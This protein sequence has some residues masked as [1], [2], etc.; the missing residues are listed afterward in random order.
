MGQRRPDAV[1]KPANC[2]GTRSASG[3]LRSGEG[4]QLQLLFADTEKG[5]P[6]MFWQSSAAALNRYLRTHRARASELNNGRVHLARR[7]CGAGG[8]PKISAR[9]PIRLSPADLVFFSRAVC[10]RPSAGLEHTG[11]CLPFSTPADN[12]LFCWLF[13]LLECNKLVLF[14]RNSLRRG[15]F[16]P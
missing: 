1:V 7:C 8:T 2:P 15:T 13:S 5:F 9:Y 12:L 14:L 4:S 3:V 10:P 11:P 6:F 16:S